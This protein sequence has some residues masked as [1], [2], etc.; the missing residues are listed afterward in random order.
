MVNQNQK[1]CCTGLAIATVPMQVWREVYRP[2]TAFMN[3]T[4]F[5]E[6]NLP[7][8]GRSGNMGN[9]LQGRLNK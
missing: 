4:I 5:P 1:A 7:Y 2:E 6:L 9:T 8:T 3:G